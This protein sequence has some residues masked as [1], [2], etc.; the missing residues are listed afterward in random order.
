MEATPSEIMT[1]N[2]AAEF[3]RVPV[4]TIYMLAQKGKIPSQKVG[5]HWRF[6]RGTLINWIA[7]T[8]VKERPEADVVNRP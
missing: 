3:L 7:D 2:E 1:V 4:S 6:H 8:K 5:R